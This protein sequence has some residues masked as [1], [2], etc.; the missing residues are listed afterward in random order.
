MP[1]VEAYLEAPRLFQQF[2]LEELERDPDVLRDPELSE[3][4]FDEVNEL[5]S[6]ENQREL[7]WYKAQV[8]RRLPQ[9]S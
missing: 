6:T 5:V 7:G 2:F 9:A 4:I 8:K 1:W 3:R